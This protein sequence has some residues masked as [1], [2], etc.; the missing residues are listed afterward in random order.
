MIELITKIYLRFKDWWI[1]NTFLLN[2]CYMKNIYLLHGF[3]GL[4][5]DWDF[6]KADFSN[7]HLHP[8]PLYDQFYPNQGIDPFSIQFNRIID[9]NAQNYLVGY[10]LGGRLAL[11]ALLDQPGLWKGTSLISTH[12]GLQE[13]GERATRIV[14]DGIWAMRMLTMKWDD[15]MHKWNEQPVFAY[16]KHFD[17]KEEDF[18]R[19]VLADVLTHWSLGQQENLREKI[20]QLELP[21]QWIVGKNDSKFMDLSKT[22][23]LKH[24]KSQ[25][26]AVE[27]AGHRVPW[28]N[29][30][31]FISILKTLISE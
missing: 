16:S 10:S 6:L 18:E 20:S 11:H 23:D 27:D 24:P 4:P 17:R 30:S 2:I 14:N 7:Y 9:P 26:L 5:S 31:R 1:I 12:P 15:L 19:D 25:I 28:D 21:I 3:L 13:E 29:P 22:I 8:I